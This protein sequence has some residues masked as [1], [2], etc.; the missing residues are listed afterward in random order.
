MNIDH[1]DVNIAFLNN[2]LLEKKI[3]SPKVDSRNKDKVYLL[4]KAIYG[5]KQ[6]SRV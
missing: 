3:I 2:K 5:F 4:K 1:L 6:S